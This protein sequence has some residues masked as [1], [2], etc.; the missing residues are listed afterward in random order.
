MEILDS[1]RLGLEVALSWENLL[2]V[3]VG[4]TIGNIIGVLPGLGSAGTIALLLPLTYLLPPESAIIMLAGIFYG[5]AYG[6]TITSVLLKLPGEATTIVTTFDGHA[7]ALKGKAGLALGLSAI[8]SFIGGT[9]AVIGLTFL[10]APFATF[11]LQFG[12]PEYTVLAAFGVLLV[13]YLSNGSMTRGFV[14]AALGLLLATIGQDPILGSNRFTGSIAGLFG[15]IEFTAVA[16]GL[17]GVG[18]MLGAIESSHRAAVRPA[19]VSR[20]LPTK[21]EM[22]RSMPSILRGS[23]LGF[24]LGVLPGGGATIASM[25]SYGLEKRISKHPEEFGQ[26]ALE[27]VAGP[28]T[29][30]NAAANSSFIPLLSLG[31][32]ANTT[33][34]VIFGALMLQGVTPGPLLIQSHPQVFWGVIVSMYI[35][36]IVLII[37]NIPFVKLFTKMLL[38]PIRI[39]APITIVVTLVGVYTVNNSTLDVWVALIFGILGYLLKKAGFEPAPLALAFVLGPLLEESF[40]QSM[41]ISQGSLGVFVTR[42]I[43]GAFLALVAI[44]VATTVI[45]KKVK[46]AAVVTVKDLEEAIDE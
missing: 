22:R 33:M 34:A 5:S 42:P 26:G 19:Q 15:G 36:N 13:S 12:P 37:L 8:G 43:S 7:L 41:I 29:A 45:R 9:L 27:G 25:A 17:F 44:G 11:A 20:V 3:F 1:L 35:G 16:M 24:F 21:K 2:W 10:A 38:V 31:I 18:E 32:P 30:N 6:G 23:A 46:P 28:E 4:V 14:V 40:R 39:L